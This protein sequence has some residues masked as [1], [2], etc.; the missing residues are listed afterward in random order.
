MYVYNCRLL[1]FQ[2]Y[3]TIFVFYQKKNVRAFNIILDVTMEPV[4][5]ES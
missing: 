1:S 2:Y 3:V 4:A 5:F